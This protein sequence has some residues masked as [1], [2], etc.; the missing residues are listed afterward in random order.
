MIFNGSMLL[1]LSPIEDMLDHKVKQNGVSHGLS[2]AGYDIRIKQD[3]TFYP[4]KWIGGQWEGPFILIDGEFKQGRFCLAS[5][6]ERFTMP[7][8]LVGEVKDK[9]S[10][11]R[12]GLSVFNT[13]IEPGWQGWLTLELHFCADQEVT[14]HSGSGIAQVLFYETSMAAQYEGKYQNAENHPQTALDY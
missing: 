10:W 7:R 3:I 14:I 5:S 11:A 4:G 13:V 8:R 2:E 6:M 12:Q 9:S 1:K